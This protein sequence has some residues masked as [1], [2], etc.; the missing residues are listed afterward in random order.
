LLSAITVWACSVPVFRYALERWPADP[1]QAIVFHQ[2][3]LDQETLDLLLPYMPDGPSLEEPPPVNLRVQTVNLGKGNGSDPYIILLYPSGSGLATPA[4]SG[5]WQDE[6]WQKWID[7]PMRQDIGQRL[8]AGASAVWVLLENADSFANDAAFELLKTR[9]AHLESNLEMEELDQADIDQGLVSISQDQLKISFPLVRLS[10]DDSREKEFV[11]MLLGIEPDLR[12]L[13]GP[14][15][16]P[17]FGRGRALYA[18]VGPGINKETIDDAARFLIGP[19]SCQV[20]EL[21]PGVDLL[22]NTDWDNLVESS[23]NQDQELPPLTGF[24]GLPPAQDDTSKQAPLDSTTSLEPPADTPPETGLTDATSTS[25]LFRRIL[26][27]GSIVF[28]IVAGFTGWIIF[29]KG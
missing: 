12:S 5:S 3:A 18:L 24:A 8:A 10:R 1:Y 23:L 20:K 2:G 7:S 14:M 25:P 9:L 17:I 22:L 19:C 15:A 13:P 11:E 4:W 27:L 6:A 26:L 16:F 21:N 29:K 28:L